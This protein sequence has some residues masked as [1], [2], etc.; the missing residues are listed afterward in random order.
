[1]IV[2]AQPERIAGREPL[3]QVLDPGDRLHEIAGHRLDDAGV[4]LEGELGLIRRGRRRRWRSRRRWRRRRRSRGSRRQRAGGGCRCRPLLRLRR[5]WRLL[6]GLH[7]RRAARHDG[8]ALLDLAEPL[9]RLLAELR[10][11]V[12]QDLAVVLEPSRHLA[13]VEALDVI[14]RQLEPSAGRVHAD[15]VAEGVLGREELGLGHLVSDRGDLG[16]RVGARRAR[17]RG[18]CRAR[19]VVDGGSRPSP[20]SRA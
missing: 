3:M 13:R 15:V 19:V 1:M 2:D 16:R 18:R 5:R 20:I 4:V 6:L 8:E 11:Q 7:W 17:R 14:L 10:L 12:G 9:G